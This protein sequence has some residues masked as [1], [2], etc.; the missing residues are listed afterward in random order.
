MGI[1]TENIKPKIRKYQDEEKIKYIIRW[2][3]FREKGVEILIE[4]IYNV[5]QKL[6]EKN[7]ISFS[8]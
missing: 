4:S 5:K 6:P 8:W 7:K 3:I 1:N 2:K